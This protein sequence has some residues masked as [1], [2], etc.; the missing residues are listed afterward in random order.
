MRA[1]ADTWGAIGAFTGGMTGALK[2]PASIA[3]LPM[4]LPVARGI[5]GT[6]LAEGAI[7][8]GVTALT[9]PDTNRYRQEQGLDPRTRRRPS[10][11]ARPA[12]PCS[13]AA[14]ARSAG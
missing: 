12:V 4:G 1:R 11:S 3:T 9:L 6:A 2:D 5:I 8:G 13:A 14:R 7:G 10:C